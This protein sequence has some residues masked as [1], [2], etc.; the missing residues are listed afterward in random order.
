[1]ELHKSDLY[2]ALHVPVIQ[3]PTEKL[4]EL[5]TVNGFCS[6]KFQR[7]SKNPKNTV[8][9]VTAIPQYLV[10]TCLREA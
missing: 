6:P 7:P 8:R 2:V 10:K 5:R 9:P 3:V 4:T 1:M